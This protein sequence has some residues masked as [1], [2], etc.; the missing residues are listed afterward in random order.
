MMARMGT[1]SSF[2]KV[3]IGVIDDD[4]SICRSMSRLLRAA[5]FE[6][7]TYLSA[8]SFLADRSHPKF[9]CLVL[10]VRLKGIS[11]LE[12]RQRLSAV[13][14]S[15]PVIFITAHEDPAVRL[16]AEALGCDGFFQKTAS[17]TDILA[18]LRRI[19]GRE[20]TASGGNT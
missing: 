4:Q 11:G 15:T 6:P 1:E 17:G 2:E 10:D 16:Q 19:T 8:E 18:R 9:G 13:H 12:L 7:V 5:R 14:D 3:Y 20:A